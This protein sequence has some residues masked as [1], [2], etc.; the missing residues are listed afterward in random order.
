MKWFTADT[1]FGHEN[2]RGMGIIQ[3]MA[4]VKPNGEIFSCAAEHDA[5]LVNE[6]NLCF[7]PGDTLFVLG[8]FAWDKPG[9]FRPALKVKHIRCILGNHDKPSK[10]SQVFGQ[11]F[12]TLTTKL[13]G[14]YK[15]KA[16]L[17]HY[18]HAYWD[19]SHKGHIHLYGH[20]HGMREATLDELF[21]ERRSMDVGV[22]NAYRLL[23]AYRPFSE[24]EILEIM[25]RRTG[26]DDVRWYEDWRAEL[27]ATR[28][29]P[30]KFVPRLD[31]LGLCDT[32]EV[33]E[34][35]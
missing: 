28:G 5:Y 8:D 10:C 26:H 19:G 16:F 23:G 35:D 30:E 9:R 11:C 6:F 33:S 27:F 17:S 12:Q 34:D 4:R 15:E 21:P 7:S 14:Q 13:E 18:P 2:R 24:V 20:V 29:Y 25:A 31:K 32:V 22:D 1:H 3:M